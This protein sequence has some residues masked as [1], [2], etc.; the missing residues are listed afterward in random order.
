MVASIDSLFPHLAV[1]N[2]GAGLWNNDA[3]TAV[4]Y[5][6]NLGY[7]P[8]LLVYLTNATNFILIPFTFFNVSNGTANLAIRQYS[9]SVDNTNVYFTTTVTTL[10]MSD[11]APNLPARIYLLRQP[12]A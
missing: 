4:A 2:A 9:A 12:P 5:P 8:S 1:T 10:G 7:T 11:S 3:T 6:H